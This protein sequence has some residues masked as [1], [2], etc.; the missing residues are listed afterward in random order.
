MNL[1]GLRWNP[2][3]L[4]WRLILERNGRPVD[5]GDYKNLY[6]ALQARDLALSIDK[7]LALPEQ[8]RGP[9]RPRK[10]KRQSVRVPTSVHEVAVQAA[11]AA[12]LDPRGLRPRPRKRNQKQGETKR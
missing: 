9:G 11:L 3:D 12:G 10:N 1:R 2:D 4:T 5:L 7:T 6:R 8:K